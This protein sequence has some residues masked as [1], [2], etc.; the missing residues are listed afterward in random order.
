M[1]LNNTRSVSNTGV[2]RHHPNAHLDSSRPCTA[3]KIFHEKSPKLCRQGTAKTANIKRHLRA[4]TKKANIWKAFFLLKATT[5]EEHGKEEENPWARRDQFLRL[6]GISS[7]LGKILKLKFFSSTSRLCLPSSTSSNSMLVCVTSA[8]VPM[9]PCSSNNALICRFN[10]NLC[11]F[12]CAI[13]R[14]KRRLRN[15]EHYFFA[16]YRTRL[17]FIIYLF[18]AG[19]VSHKRRDSRQR[20]V[21]ALPWKPN[22][23]PRQKS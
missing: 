1:Q 14:V 10:L 18:S 22:I 6:D 9:T 23:K 3:I 5:A 15:S 2:H 13:W 19:S 8:E 4:H 7:C 21:V 17:I 11:L 16:S 12:D 20:K